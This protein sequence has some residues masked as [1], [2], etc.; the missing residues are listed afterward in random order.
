M[1]NRGVLVGAQSVI[2]ELSGA[3][4]ATQ[5]SRITYKANNFK[6][7]LSKACYL[8]GWYRYN[9]DRHRPVF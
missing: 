8:P 7:L 3:E 9:R 5:M 4:Q 6:A 2:K 1:W